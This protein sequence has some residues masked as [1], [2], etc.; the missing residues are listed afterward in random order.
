MRADKKVVLGV[1]QSVRATA[2]TL[3]DGEKP[4]KW[5]IVKTL[6]PKVKTNAKFLNLEGVFYSS[7]N[8]ECCHYIRDSI[9][10]LI[11]MYDPSVVCFEALS[12]SSIGNVTRDLAY[13][14]GCLTTVCAYS[15]YKDSDI[16]KFAPT[17][18][19]HHARDWLP[20]EEQYVGVLK[21]GKP[22][23]R[24]MEKEDMVHAVAAKLGEDADAF[25][26]GYGMT[27]AT[28]GRD[29]LAD[30]F[31]IASLGYKHFYG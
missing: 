3:Y 17:A 13:L 19:K 10:D 2:W 24:K 14:L 29:D 30:S 28:K 6:D 9:Q 23:L 27:G 20:K 22:A 25:F 26:K 15:G 16:M 1:D 8:I 11:V 5:G 31:T 7:D 12:F 21:S 18:V 4:L